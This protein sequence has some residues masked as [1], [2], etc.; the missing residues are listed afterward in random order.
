MF[1]PWHR[2]RA[3]L[4]ALV[5]AVSLLLSTA[6]ATGAP[7][8]EQSLVTAKPQPVI[9]AGSNWSGTVEVID[10]NRRYQP[11]GTINVVPDLQ[12]RM[13]EI[14]TDPERLAYFLAIRMLPGEGHDQ[15]VDDMYSSPDGKIL[16]ASRPSLADVVGIEIVTGKILWRFE[17]AGHRSDHMGLS[18]DGRRVAVSASTGNVVHILD[19]VT[20]RELGQ[21]PSGDQ[22]HE[23]VYSADGKHIYHASIGTVFTPADQPALDATKGKRYF[24]VVDAETLAVLERVD[25]RPRLDEAGYAHLSSAIRP[26]AHTADGRLFYF[27]LSFFHGFVEYDLLADRIRRVATLPN[28]IPDTPREEYVNDS[29]HHGIALNGAGTKLCVAGTMSDY[30]AIVSR[31]TFSHK[32]VRRPEEGKPYWATTSKDG[33]YCFVSWSGTD[34]ISVISYDKEAEVAR[35]GVGDHPQRI[36]EGFVPAGWTTL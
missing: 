12:E 35:I 17:V 26:M 27:Q 33:K 11:I 7:G 31:S 29:A 24:Q 16:V 15:L 28:L 2:H 13:A 1:S 32:I 18:P 36:R 6:P 22:P 8:A 23:N 4:G 9:F 19:V 14:Y 5:A 21:F 34:E 25:L 10:P 3:A 30:V 20:G